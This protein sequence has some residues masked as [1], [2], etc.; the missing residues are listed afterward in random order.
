[1]GWA[2][3]TADGLPAAGSVTG[4]VAHPAFVAVSADRDDVLALTFEGISKL[5]R[6]SPVTLTFDDGT[7][8]VEYR[9][10]SAFSDAGMT[11]AV[12]GTFT[13]SGGKAKHVLRVAGKI[14]TLFVQASAFISN[15]DDYRAEADRLSGFINQVAGLARTLPAQGIEFAPEDD[16]GLGA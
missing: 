1:M 14:G 5:D 13:P 11:Y 8:I 9:R 10:A 6:C 4:T 15:P 2:T 7:A 16:A 3:L 12:I